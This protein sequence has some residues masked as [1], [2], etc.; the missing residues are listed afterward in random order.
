M[1][2]VDGD[3]QNADNPVEGG[4]YTDNSGEFP[5]TDSNEFPNEQTPLLP[6]P[7]PDYTARPVESSS[8]QKT[9]HVHGRMQAIMG[10][11]NYQYTIDRSFEGP[12]E[13]QGSIEHPPTDNSMSSEEL[14][15]IDRKNNELL[16]SHCCTKEQELV[17]PNDYSVLHIGSSHNNM[18]GVKRFVSHQA[19]LLPVCLENADTVNNSSDEVPL[20]DA[21]E[22]A[23]V[24]YQKALARKVVYIIHYSDSKE[25]ITSQLK[26]IL[27]DLGVEILTIEDA[28]VGQTIANARDELVNKADKVIVVFS[29]KSKE[30]KNALESKWLQ[31]DLERVKHKNPDPN[32]ISFIPILYEDTEQKDLPRPLDNMIALKADS[33]NLKEKLKESIFDKH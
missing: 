3:H 32:K 5:N 20:K 28:V 27:D 9:E 30:D 6:K 18:G 33:E 16:S 4:N 25:W 26:P 11:T 13:A 29:R 2:S 31:Y 10:D 23:L 22:H 19:D 8:E 12:S 17:D 1:S 7:E 15:S 24:P 21:N 14:F